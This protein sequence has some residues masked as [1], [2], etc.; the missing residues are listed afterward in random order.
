MRDVDLHSLGP[1]VKTGKKI[2]VSMVDITDIIRAEPGLGVE[3]L[4]GSGL[5]AGESS[6]VYVETFTI[7]YICSSSVVIGA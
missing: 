3:K 1:Y 6:R 5:I 7:M 2:N 4:K